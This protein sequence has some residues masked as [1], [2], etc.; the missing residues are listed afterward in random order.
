MQRLFSKMPLRVSHGR[1]S[2]DRESLPTD[3]TL[4]VYQHKT[5][6]MQSKASLCENML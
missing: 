6:A 4:V 5:Y 1:C 2:N 3:W